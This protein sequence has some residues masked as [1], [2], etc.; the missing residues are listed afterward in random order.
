[1]QLVSAAL[2]PSLF[3]TAPPLPEVEFPVMVQL[4]S[5]AMP[6]LL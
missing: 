6:A 3:H 1:M 2:P 5:V 4:V